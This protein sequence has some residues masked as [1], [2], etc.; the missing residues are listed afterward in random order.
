[1]ETDDHGEYQKVAALR[2]RPG[3][4]RRF[5]ALRR[6]DTKRLIRLRAQTDDGEFHI[7]LPVIL[8]M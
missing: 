5:K 4:R 6:G 8:R 1:M 2:L 7:E 3:E